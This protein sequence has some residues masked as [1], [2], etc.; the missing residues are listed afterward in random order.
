MSAA[1]HPVL[2]DDA[3]NPWH[4][5]ELAQRLHGVGSPWCIVGGWALD[6]W[7]GAQTREHDDLEFSVLRGDFA[8]FRSALRDMALFTAG[9]GIVTPLAPDAE[10]PSAIFQIWCQDIAARCWRVDMMLEPG[11]DDMW[12]FRRDP[13]LTRPRADMIALSGE[14][15]PYLKPAGVLLFKAKHRRPKDDADFELAVPKL[16]A[17]ERLW[18]KAALLRTHPGHAWLEVL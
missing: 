4:P 9:N 5:R 18:L 11:S 17:P 15:I 14:G 12:A 6:L 1:A 2:P 7:H 8:I 3:W 10:P 16:A 13:T